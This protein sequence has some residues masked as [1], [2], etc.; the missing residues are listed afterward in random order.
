MKNKIKLPHRKVKVDFAEH[1]DRILEDNLK[2][3][4]EE[5]FGGTCFTRYKKIII[6]VAFCDYIGLKITNPEHVQD[7]LEKAWK[8]IVKNKCVDEL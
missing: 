7:C 4:A 3:S 1:Y 8:E 5:D 6:W 2:F